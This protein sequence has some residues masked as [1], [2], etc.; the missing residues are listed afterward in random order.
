MLIFLPKKFH[1]RTIYDIIREEI[2]EDFVYS[3]YTERGKTR[4]EGNILM[5]IRLEAYV[6]FY[7]NV[8]F[9]N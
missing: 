4:E 1:N 6:F 7:S 5:K 9:Y 2:S 8:F 3:F